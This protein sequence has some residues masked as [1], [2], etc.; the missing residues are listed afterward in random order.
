M[1]DFT[2]E[3][4]DDGIATIRFDA[5]GRTMNTLTT[6][7][8]DDLAAIVETVRE[9]DAIRGAIIV[10]GKANAFCAGADLDEM[11]DAAGYTPASAEEQRSIVDRMGKANRVARALETC[12]KPIVAAIAGHALG[13]GLELALACHHRIVADDP[14]IKLGL[15]EASIGLLPGGGGTQRLLRLLGMARALPLLLEGRTLKPAEALSLGIIDAVVAKGEEVVAARAWIAAGGSPQARWDR[16]DFVLPGG[17]PYSADGNPVF[18][19]S[20]A[21]A[22]RRSQGNYP[23]IG[24]IAHAL[25]EGAQ[26]PIDRAL[27]IETRYFVATLQS[28]QA[29]AMIRTLF[30]SHPALAKAEDRPVA[31]PPASYRVIGVLGAGMMGAGIAFVSAEAGLDVILIDTSREAA[32]RGK[33]YA[34]SV[35]DRRV[36]KGIIAQEAADAIV[37]RIR[38]SDDY[39]DLAPC[40]LVVETV[41]EDREVK[42]E[43]TRRAAA[44][45][46]E[47]VLFASNTSTLPITGL[48]EA[49][50]DPHRYIGMHF[51]SPVDRMELV[52]IVLGKE[53]DETALAHALDYVK[54]IRKTAIVVRDSPFFYTSRTFDTYIREGMEM[55]VDGY[56]PTLIDAAGKLAGMPRGPLELTDDVAIDLVDRIAGQRRLSLG[57]AAER[58]RSDDVIDLLIREGRYGRKNG[59]GFYDYAADGTKRLWPGLAEA[60]PVTT[61]HSTPELVDTLKRR[62]L[63]RQAV[64]AARCLSEG[65]LTD[66]RHA[67]VGAVLGWSFPRWT[68]GPISLIDQVGA[69]RFSAECDVLADTCGPRFLVPDALRAMA[70]TGRSYYGEARIDQVAA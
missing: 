19:Q 22:A 39:G 46:R 60:W 47:G 18:I 4:G 3:R 48:A 7:G 1:T 40:D 65:V 64:E 54:A 5:A 61:P 52:E 21:I 10:S 70:A 29:K 17:T 30:H 66:P 45:V 53:T 16:R 67:D 6:R 38:P 2:L 35:L 41:F 26:V 49:A 33:A 9:D 59:R 23:A 51:H 50:P 27:Q 69:A 28:P 55:L 12:G 68:G 20:A 32:E 63:Y 44:A 25:Y 56:A 8:W 34:R 36:A 62:F 31:P 57:A 13:G 14:R 42:G 37:A 24:N 58:R 43:A 15:P 11:L